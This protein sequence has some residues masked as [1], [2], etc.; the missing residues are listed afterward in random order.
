MKIIMVSDHA[1]FNLKEELKRFL[2]PLV[3]GMEDFGVFS[4]ELPADDYPCWRPKR[5]REYLARSSTE[6]FSSAVRASV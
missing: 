5:P 2:V 3:Q 6:E 4:A 1:G